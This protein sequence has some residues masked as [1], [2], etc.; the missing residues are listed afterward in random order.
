MANI[1]VRNL[2]DEVPKRLKQQA[3]E[4]GRSMEVEARSILT[5]A[6]TRGG[7]AQAWVEATADLRG[8][9]SGRL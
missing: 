9:L 1:T 5:A 7:L 4:H 3:V 8:R 2:D 6:P